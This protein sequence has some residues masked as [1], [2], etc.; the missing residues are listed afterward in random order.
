[1]GHRSRRI[2][3]V[4]LACAL[5]AACLV[6]PASAQNRTVSAAAFHDSV[7]VTTHP[8]YYDTPYGRWADVVAR[9]RELGVAHMRS[10]V[11]ASA[12]AGWNARHWGDLTA[13]ANAGIRL[14]LIVNRDCADAR[15]MDPCLAVVRSQLPPGSVDFL[16]WDDEADLEGGTSWAPRLAAWGRELYAKVKAD[17]QLAGIPVVGPALTRFGSPELLGDQS[18]FLDRGSIHPYTG[19]R[20]PTAALVEAE[21]QHIRP[22]SGTKTVLA[23]ESGFHTSPQASGPGQPPTD[24]ATAAV[25]TL[26]TVLEHYLSG[27]PRT[28]VY[29]LVD[30]FDDRTRPEANYGLLHHDFSP[31]PAFTAL[32]NML[33]MAGTAAPA[34]IT[35]LLFRISGDTGDLRHLA[36]QQADRSYLLVLWRTASVWDR[37]ARRPLSVAPRSFSVEVPG[38]VSLARGNPLAGPGLTAGAVSGARFTQSVAAHPVVLRLGIAPGGQPPLS[39]VAGSGP[40]GSGTAGGRG[41]S[42]DR[43]RPRV[44]KVKVKKIARRRW[45]VYFRLSEPATVA[46]RLDRGR[47]GSKKRYRLLKRIAAKRMVKVTG[48]RRIS[49]GYLRVGRH[50]V[51]L[52]A[53]DAAGNRTNVLVAFKIRAATRR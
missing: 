43:T 22:V 23:T 49:V 42:N 38:A 26:R 41:G 51:L 20:S 35:P 17:P 28:Y 15:T 29:E 53:R 6:S 10:G 52:S 36:L 11:Y 33:A 48:Q 39:G 37:D 14:H 50:R 5:T 47:K 18:A 12:N 31:K 32:K 13:L 40:S 9:L 7:G 44:S 19:A 27:I 45:A 25:Y 24:E 30:E 34:T 8:T 46:T 1:V 16:E 3:R 2:V 21:R 4:G